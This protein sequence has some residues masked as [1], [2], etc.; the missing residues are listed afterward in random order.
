M[1]DLRRRSAGWLTVW[2]GKRFVAALLGLPPADAPESSCAPKWLLLDASPAVFLPG[3]LLGG[4]LGWFII[5][6]VNAVLG[7]FFR[8]F[9][10]VF[11]QVTAR[12]RL[13]GRP[14]CCASA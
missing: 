11:D 10:R 7:W 12:L 5:R 1:V 4:V 8:G 3:A 6:P 14:A 13:D 2:L 9:N